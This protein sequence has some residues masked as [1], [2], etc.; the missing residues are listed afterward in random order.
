MKLA[1]HI[2]QGKLLY[3]THGQDAISICEN[4]HFRWITFEGVVQSIMHRRKPSLLTLPHHLI[5]QLPLLFF[6]PDT[7]VELGLGGGNLARYVAQLDAT[8]SFI[9]VEYNTEVI[10]AFEQYFNP[11][12][13]DIT[14]INDRSE[15]WLIHPQ[16]AQVD[17]L[18]CDIYQHDSIYQS[19][20]QT[21]AQIGKLV[22]ALS[23]DSCLSI[24]L[25]D[26]TT[27]EVNLCLK[28]LQDL[29]ALTKAHRVV[30]FH[31]PN[32]LNIV[33]HVIPL[34]W[35]IKTRLKNKHYSYLSQRRFSRYRKQ[36][37]LGIAGTQALDK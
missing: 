27:T 7:V 13:I 23:A 37:Q 28:V 19:V 2:S 34:A 36:W 4:E 26:A 9:S 12:N 11:D 35:N 32:Y 21:A 20:H 25:P 31:V 17:W 15:N 14:I 16:P 6:R 22:A 3:F 24:N 30:Y 33:I 29:L 10:D 5:I 8:I 1:K 18:V